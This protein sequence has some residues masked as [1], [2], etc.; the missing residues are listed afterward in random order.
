MQVPGNSF[1]A[2]LCPAS[3]RPAAY[4]TE[5]FVSDVFKIPPQKPDK[6]RIVNVQR[7]I[8]LD[9]VQTITVELPDGS[10]GCKIFAAGNIYLGVQYSADREDQ[11]VHF[12]R[13]Q[14][15][16]Q[17]LIHQP[18]PEVPGLG[19]LIPC[20]AEIFEEGYVVHVCVEKLNTKQIDNR[21][22]L[23][24]VLLLVWVEQI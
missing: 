13:F 18:C 22:I 3:E 16:F 12:V 14:L 21:T 7:S 24:E 4:F 10:E 11:T 17:A 8:T 9:D 15:P 19:G 20:D 5:I 6:E 23:V 2:E 1:V